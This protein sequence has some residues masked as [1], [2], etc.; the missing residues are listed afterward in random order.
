MWEGLT[1]ARSLGERDPKGR[2]N[3][4]AEPVQLTDSSPGLGLTLQPR[5]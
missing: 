2:E 1:E 5:A 3:G 4:R